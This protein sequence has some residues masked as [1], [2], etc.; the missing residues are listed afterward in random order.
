MQI[1]TVLT[2]CLFVLS[3]AVSTIVVPAQ[4]PVP[5]EGATTGNQTS[6]RQLPDYMLGP[7]DEIVIMAIEAEEITNKPIRIGVPG[8]ITL[9][10][11]GRVLALG[12]TVQ[13]LESEISKRLKMYVREPQVSISVTQL[14]S[15]PVTVIGAVGKPG[16]VQLEGRKTLVEVLSLAGGTQPEASSRISITRKK[17]AGV[18]PLG[19][20]AP[21]APSSYSVSEVDLQSIMDGSRPEQNIQIHPHDLITV[22]RAPIVYAV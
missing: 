6:N 1:R 15:Q 19:S 7:G 9:P 22:P 5:H 2:Q 8:D 3:F 14:R 21:E 17:E 10:M 11:V 12:M 4:E 18:Q 13:E 16:V 20:V